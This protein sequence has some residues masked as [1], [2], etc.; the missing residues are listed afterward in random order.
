MKAAFFGLA[1]CSVS[2]LACRLGKLFGEKE[3]APSALPTQAP[4]PPELLPKAPAAAATPSASA[5]PTRP[6]SEYSM[7]GISPTVDNCKDAWAVLATVPAAL[8]DKP[9]FF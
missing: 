6:A 1:M 3:E 7:A 2:L 4:L 5:E 9:D 8:H